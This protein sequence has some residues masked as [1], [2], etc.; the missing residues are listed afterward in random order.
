MEERKN[1]E[2]ESKTLEL[3]L[4][5]FRTEVNPTIE[6]IENQ[7]KALYK[8]RKT[9]RRELQIQNKIWEWK[10]GDKPHI[11]LANGVNNIVSGGSEEKEVMTF[12]KTGGWNE[13]R[14][15][16]YVEMGKRS[17]EL[18]NQLKIN[19]DGQ[20]NINTMRNQ[21]D[22]SFLMAAVQNED[23]ETARFCLKLGARPDERNSNGHTAL[24]F[25]NYFNLHKF[26]KLLIQ[27]GATDVGTNAHWDAILDQPVPVLHRIDWI[28]TLRIAEKAAIST[29]T[30]IISPDTIDTDPNWR[31]EMLSIAEQKADYSCFD[32]SLTNPS[33]NTFQRIVLLEKNVCKWLLEADIPERTLFRKF[34]NGLKP[35]DI[36]KKGGSVS[37][38]RRAIIGS[39]DLFEG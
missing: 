34:L 29:G 35:A 23:E 6:R 7:M 17:K 28:T 31:M 33:E 32:D 1:K 16:G 21:N 26:S 19:W 11:M 37:C 27:H 15:Q 13:E 24:F 12:L 9:P 4:T 30:Q 2:N 5:K 3:K 10:L 22:L 20:F 14:L 36:R 8:E 38:H 39:K 25:A 18:N